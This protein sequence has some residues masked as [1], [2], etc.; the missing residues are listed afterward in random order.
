MELRQLEYLVAIATYKTVSKASQEL[1]VSQPALTRSIQSLEDELGYNLFDR[2]KNR[3][4]L[5]DNGEII[6]N[7]AKIILNQKDKMLHELENYQ[8]IK[9]QIV[10]GS[11]APAPL[12]GVNYI[13]KDVHPKLKITTSIDDTEQLITGLQEHLYSII[14]L[15]YSINDKK[16]NSI[17]LLDEQLYLAV[18]KDHPLASK[19]ELTFKEIDGTNI[20][21]LSQTGYWYEMCKEQLPNSTIIE[22]D[23]YKTYEILCSSSS[24]ATFRTNITIQKLKKIE[25]KIYIPIIDNLATMSFYAIYDKQYDYIYSHIKPNIETI[26]WEKFDREEIIN[27]DN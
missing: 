17:P 2:V 14:I 15:D 22:Q 26:P 19:K 27:K 6:V 20:L 7:H 16:Y 18:N 21:Q 23:D 8:Q 12:W 24:L 13:L 25:D 4:I 10:I 5:N 9:H 3:L 11:C 1:L